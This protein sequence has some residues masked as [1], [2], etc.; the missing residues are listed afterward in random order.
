MNDQR[1][2]LGKCIAVLVGV[3]LLASQLQAQQQQTKLTVR[4]AKAAFLS[5]LAIESDIS[6]AKDKS[7]EATEMS[8]TQ[9]QID[10][11]EKERQGANRDTSCD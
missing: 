5:L 4:Y 9:A 6:T 10:A 2:A 1:Y 11:E 7:S 8:A 3:F